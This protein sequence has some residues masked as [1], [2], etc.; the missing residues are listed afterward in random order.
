MRAR[1]AA[2]ARSRS[3]PATCAVPPDG[4]QQA[5]QHAEGGGFAGAVGTE[6]S[7]R[8]RRAHAK[9]TWSTATKMPKRRTRSRDHDG[10][11]LG[12]PLRRMPPPLREGSVEVVRNALT[13]PLPDPPSREGVATRPR[14]PLPLRSR[15]MKPSSKRGGS[16]VQRRAAE[17]LGLAASAPARSTMRSVSP[18]TSASSTAGCVRSAAGDGA[19]PRRW[20]VRR[21]TRP[22]NRCE[23]LVRRRIGQQL[24]PG[25]AAARGRSA[26]PRRDRRWPR[27]RP[28]R[29]RGLPP[30]WPDDRP[31]FAARHRID[32]DRW[33]VQQQQARA[34]QQRAG[35]AQLLLHAAGQ[36]ARPAA[37]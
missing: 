19:A 37:R 25:A 3:R 21:N 23:E 1:A 13:Q 30:A 28:C 31:E 32:A 12:G 29:R 6:Q 5:A 10:G 34:R 33:L 4:C 36:L 17:V 35:Q 27:P 9:L 15:S 20:H 14:A 18:A 8:F 26:R 7:R 22:C 11:R 24:C 16:G 2:G